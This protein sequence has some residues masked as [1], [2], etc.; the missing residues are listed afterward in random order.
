MSPA[1][2]VIAAAVISFLTIM[3]LPETA[4]RPLR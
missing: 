4:R 3:M 1:L 2:Y